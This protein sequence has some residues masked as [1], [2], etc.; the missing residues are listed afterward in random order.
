MQH[1][2]LRVPHG[3]AQSVQAPSLVVFA[4]P[5]DA[6]TAGTA[7]IVVLLSVPP[8]A[9]LATR[10]SADGVPDVVLPLGAIAVRVELEGSADRD[11]VVA[12]DWRVL[13][14]RQ[15]EWA[16]E[17][18]RCSVLR[19]ASDGAMRGLTSLGR[20]GPAQHLGSGCERAHDRRKRKARIIWRRRWPK[21]SD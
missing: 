3:A 19:P 18:R 9:R 20:G 17:G 16:Q 6:L 10:P 14:V 13:D 15:F 2:L 12:A 8:S 7:H 1:A 11:A 5:A 4:R 21:A